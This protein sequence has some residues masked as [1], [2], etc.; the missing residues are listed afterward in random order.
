MYHYIL[1]ARWRMCCLIYIIIH[2]RK[3][4]SN[5]KR[6][7]YPFINVDSGY[8]NPEYLF[9]KSMRLAPR[10]PASSTRDYFIFILFHPRKRFLGFRIHRNGSK[11]T[12]MLNSGNFATLLSAIRR[13]STFVP[14]PPI[15]W[16]I[17]R[18]T[19]HSNLW[20]AGICNWGYWNERRVTLRPVSSYYPIG[21]N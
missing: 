21:G 9:R 13:N 3:G 5:R 17:F 7:A 6:G 10:R 19:S 11:I 18:Q 1:I 8:N 2:E 15:V 4:R 20:F 14:P 12:V 16:I